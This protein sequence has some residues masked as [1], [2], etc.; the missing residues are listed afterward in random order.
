MDK[1]QLTMAEVPLTAS[2]QEA[3]RKTEEMSFEEALAEL[4]AVVRK[5]ESGEAALDQSLELFKKGTALSAHCEKK[6]TAAETV[7]NQLVEGADGEFTEE[8]FSLTD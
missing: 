8:P 4:E 6:L 5:L 2:E 7:V 3:T 1:E